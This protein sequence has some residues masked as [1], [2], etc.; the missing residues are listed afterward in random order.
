MIFTIYIAYN[1]ITFILQCRTI[2]RCMNILSDSARQITLFGEH[3][4][5]NEDSGLQE[6]GKQLVS[7]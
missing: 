2:W 6:W 1:W 5:N 4:L 7:Q 3:L